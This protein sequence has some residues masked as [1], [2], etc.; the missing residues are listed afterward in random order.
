MNE[1]GP[2]LPALAARVGALRQDQPRALESGQRDQ[3]QHDIDHQ[4][5]AR[6][7]AIGVAGRQAGRAYTTTC[8]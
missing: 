6:G 1:G 8:Q 3:Q 4:Q 2:Q 5:R 7:V